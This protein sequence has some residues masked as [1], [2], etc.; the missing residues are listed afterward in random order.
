VKNLYLLLN[1]GSILIPFLVTFHP[2]LKFYKKWKSFFIGTIITSIVF[3][4]WDIYFVKIGVWGFN[5]N[6]YLGYSFFGL[7][8]E[9]WMFFLFI[10]YA[11]IFMH[12]SLLKLF[13]KLSFSKTHTKY[14]SLILLC[15]FG[16]SL[17]LNHNK[18]YPIINYSLA[19]ALL[20]FVYSKNKELLSSFFKTFLAMLVPFV[21]VNGVLTGSGIEDQ[22]V[23]YNNLEN[24]G[25]R[26]LTI[27]IEDATYAFT[28]ILSTLFITEYLESKKLLK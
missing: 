9:E 4:I 3:I 14:I 2:R 16:I 19:I 13:P 7:P 25:I 26:F 27:P 6:Y 22:V 1:V 17:V 12:Y 11:C 28:M 20:L 23:W 18:W 15:Y 10:P 5:P 24:S 8:I 21:I